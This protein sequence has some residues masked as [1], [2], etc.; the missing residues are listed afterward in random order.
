MKK[1]IY[2]ISIFFIAALCSLVQ[3]QTVCAETVYNADNTEI[4]FDLNTL[5]ERGNFFMRLQI[6]ALMRKD[7]GNAWEYFKALWYMH[8]QSKLGFPGR[9]GIKL[10]GGGVYQTIQTALERPVL[11]KFVRD[12][13]DIVADSYYLK[14]NVDAVL[15]LLK[16]KGYRIVFVTN[17]DRVAYEDAMTALTSRG[18]DFDFYADAKLFYCPFNSCLLKDMKNF[19]AD[20]PEDAF[21]MVVKRAL[22]TRETEKVAYT[23]YPKPDKRFFEKQLSLAEKE[24]VLFFD[25]DLESIHTLEF[26]TQTNDHMRGH[27]VLSTHAIVNKLVNYGIFTEKEAKKIRANRYYRQEY[28]NVHGYPGLDS[29][30]Y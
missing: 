2:K 16:K 25:A 1:N 17:K 26:L 18:D 13:L 3:Q 12:M 30:T 20:A 23:P 11:Q 28:N 24:H 14:G 5:M 29:I 9:D 21:T 8:Q 22:K 15:K 27:Y 10:S 7:W 4:H 19:L 6:I